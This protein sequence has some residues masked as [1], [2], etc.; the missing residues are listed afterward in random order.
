MF[1]GASSW[2]VIVTLWLFARGCP[3]S[4][5]L[6]IPHFK[7][8]CFPDV[9]LAFYLSFFS[10]SW[11]G[12]ALTVKANFEPVLRGSDVD[13]ELIKFGAN[14]GVQYRPTTI[15]I[16]AHANET[17][18]NLQRRL[19]A[20]RLNEIIPSLNSKK[21]TSKGDEA[22]ASSL[23][24]IDE[25][26]LMMG[27]LRDISPNMNISTYGIMISHDFVSFDEDLTIL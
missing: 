9:F 24:V 10:R 11:C 8:S 23:C 6:H 21:V 20:L 22:E 25:F 19:L 16:T 13:R 17:L 18:G 26:G 7:L 4:S 27:N 1:F 3:S 5:S 12:S 2:R 15:S 14:R